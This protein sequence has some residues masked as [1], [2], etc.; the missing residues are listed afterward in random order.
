[1]VYFADT[2]K[3]MEVANASE[4][5]HL[6]MCLGCEQQMSRWGDTEQAGRPGVVASAPTEST[7]ASTHSSSS[8]GFCG[9]S[10]GVCV[11]FVFFTSGQQP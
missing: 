8:E 3:G 10:N 11:C 2:V 9:K 5:G 6:Q 4:A 7:A 1:M